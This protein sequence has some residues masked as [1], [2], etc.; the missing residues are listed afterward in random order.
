MGMVPLV[1]GF[2][3][4]GAFHAYVDVKHGGGHDAQEQ[5]DGRSDY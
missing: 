4:C 5:E 3:I 2:G 1:G